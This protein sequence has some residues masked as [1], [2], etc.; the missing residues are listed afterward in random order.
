ME[1]SLLFSLTGEVDF[2][3][4]TTPIVG[5][6]LIMNSW[7]LTLKILILNA[8]HDKIIPWWRW[9][10]QCMAMQLL[11]WAPAARRPAGW[12][13][14]RLLTGGCTVSP[15]RA[16]V[17]LNPIDQKRTKMKTNTFRENLQRDLWPLRRLI[18]LTRRHDLT[19]KRQIQRQIHLEY[20]FKERS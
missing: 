5:I 4:T 15:I 16:M 20:T 13:L 18:T 11:T 2:R 1:A 14:L 3:T 8:C 6:L 19:N 10:R 9:S 17:C 12:S 7:Q